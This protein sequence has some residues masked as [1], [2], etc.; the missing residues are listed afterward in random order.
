MNKYNLPEFGIC[1]FDGV[2]QCKVPLEKY[3]LGCGAAWTYPQPHPGLLGTL[4]VMEGR[5]AKRTRWRENPL[6]N[7]SKDAGR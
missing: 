4:R 5:K 6:H 2:K 3:T 1:D 7:Q